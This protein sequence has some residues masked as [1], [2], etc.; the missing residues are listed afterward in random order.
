MSIGPVN[1]SGDVTLIAYGTATPPRAMR[2]NLTLAETGPSDPSTVALCT[3]SR[4]TIPAATKMHHR[5]EE[6]PAPDETAALRLVT[7]VVR[8]GLDLACRTVHVA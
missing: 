4:P 2:P 3:P 8:R 1:P 7:I 6:Q 5:A